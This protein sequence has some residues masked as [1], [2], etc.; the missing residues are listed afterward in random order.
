[1]KFL[2]GE[3]MECIGTLPWHSKMQPNFNIT[4]FLVVGQKCMAFIKACQPRIHATHICTTCTCVCVFK[5]VM[6]GGFFSYFMCQKTVWK[7]YQENNDL[8]RSNSHPSWS[9]WVPSLPAPPPRLPRP[10]TAAAGLK[11][12]NLT[13]AACS[14]HSCPQWGRQEMPASSQESLLWWDFPIYFINARRPDTAGDK[15]SRL[16]MLIISQGSGPHSHDQFLF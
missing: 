7:V 8:L 12:G 9:R 6:M 15:H 13:S 4:D 11:W 10:P 14:L 3:T 2:K 1:M 5:H 16:Q